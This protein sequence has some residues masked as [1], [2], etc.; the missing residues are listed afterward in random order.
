MDRDG[1]PRSRASKAPVPCIPA[2]AEYLEAWRQE[3]PY[4]GEDDWVIP[5]FRNKG[6]A[7]RSGSSQVTDHIK[8]AALSAGV[9]AQGDEGRFGLHNL[10]AQPRHHSDFMG[11]ALQ[12]RFNPVAPRASGHNPGG[13]RARD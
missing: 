10:P 9:I 5:S 8:A 6:K 7:A 13:L 2:L 1:W 3:S 4:A 11:I 12:D